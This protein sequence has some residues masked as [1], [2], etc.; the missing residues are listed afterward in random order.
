MRTLKI[1]VLLLCFAPANWLG[2][3][4]HLGVLGGLSTQDIPRERLVILNQ[5]DIDA[6]KLSVDNADYGI[7]FGFFLR[8]EI[9]NFYIEP[10]V[11]FNSNRM[12]YRVEELTGD[13]RITL[14]KNESYQFLDLP[15]IMGLKWGILRLGAGPVGHVFIDSNSELFDLDGYKQK[16]DQMTWGWQANVG[17]DIWFLRLDL[18]YEGNFNNSGDHLEFFGHRYNFSQNP[19]RLIASIGISF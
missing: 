1:F 4:I 16:F 9:G 7:H 12:E 6:F 3:Q 10:S 18:K 8:G 15:L 19:S 14:L 17:L 5:Q 13:D 2:A 11:I